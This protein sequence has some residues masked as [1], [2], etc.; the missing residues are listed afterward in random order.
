MLHAP[1]Q[2]RSKKTLERILA[3]ART[4]M[5]TA[6]VD[7]VGITQIVAEAK[8]SVG[9]F[10]ARFDG[11]EDL[12][13]HLDGRL[14]EEAHARWEN[15]V[16]GWDPELP[17]PERIGL[18]VRLIQEAVGPDRDLR[19]AITQVLAEDGQAAQGAFDAR[20][21]QDSLSLFAQEEGIRHPKP[22]TCIPLGIRI[23]L[24][25]LRDRPEGPTPGANVD[26]GVVL[27]DELTSALRGYWGVGRVVQGAG[28]GPAVMEYFDI[29]S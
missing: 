7:A 8:S 15:G 1:K 21:T 5:G 4:L 25:T 3:S 12:V 11:K 9:S 24:S 2:T 18:L 6:G 26:S 13:R 22:A 16:S 27:A 19:S 29:W 20:V 17:A 23:V 28:S 14:W 10:Y